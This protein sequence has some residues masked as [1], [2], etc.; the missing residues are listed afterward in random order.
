M[1]TNT[2]EE[3][4]G[5]LKALAERLNRCEQVTRYDTA[6]EKQAWVL[7]HTLLDLAESFRTFL[8]EQLPQLRDERLSCDELHDVLIEIGEEFRHIL[9][10]VRDP[11]FYAYL[12]DDGP[13]APSSN[14]P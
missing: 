3:F 7:A 5:E 12:R 11:E 8:D 1:T 9:Y 13:A 4:A 2:A 10:H 6:A 14:E